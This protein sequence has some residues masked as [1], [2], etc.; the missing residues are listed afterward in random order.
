MHCNTTL[1]AVAINFLQ[2]VTD[3]ANSVKTSVGTS[4]NYSV[5]N[6]RSNLWSHVRARNER[7]RNSLV[8][9]K[10]AGFVAANAALKK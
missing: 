10:I 3:N 9:V 6:R 4:N 1:N 2:N 7:F 8:R 5:P